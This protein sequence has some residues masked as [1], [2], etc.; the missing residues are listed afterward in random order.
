LLGPIYRTLEGWGSL[1]LP[2]FVSALL[3]VEVCH[4]LEFSFHKSNEGGR[5]VTSVVVIVLNF[6]EKNLFFALYLCCS[7]ELYDCA[8]I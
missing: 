1:P 2:I 8:Q 3:R 4:E 5:A 6:N 7:V